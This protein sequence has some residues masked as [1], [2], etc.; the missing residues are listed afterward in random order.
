[1]LIFQP[2]LLHG[3]AHVHDAQ[4]QCD[5]S[6]PQ[7]S[8]PLLL[9][10]NGTLNSSRVDH[11]SSLPAHCRS[12]PPALRCPLQFKRLDFHLT[13]TSFFIFDSCWN[14]SSFFQSFQD[15][16]LFFFQFLFFLPTFSCGLLFSF[17]FPYSSLLVCLVASSPSPPSA[18]WTEQVSEP[19]DF[20]PTRL[21][22]GTRRFANS[23][24]HIVK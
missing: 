14:L 2:Y 4:S 18:T 10:N 17:I 9:Q 3:W 23:F 19:P 12:A 24:C 8:L 11:T 1:M 7:L 22:G 13:E 6:A 15:F 16:Y 21:W 5:S 20:A